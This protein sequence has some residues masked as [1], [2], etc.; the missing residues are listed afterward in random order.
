MKIVFH[1]RVYAWLKQLAARY[2]PQQEKII[3][4][5]KPY[6]EKIR[7]WWLPQQEKIAQWATPRLAQFKAHWHSL[8]AR[9]K[10]IVLGGAIVAAALLF[11]ALM[12]SPLNAHLDNLRTQIQAEK[13]TAAW[14]QAADKQIRSL[15]SKQGPVSVKK[16]ARRLN[17]IE[18][19]LR[20]APLSKNLT[21]LT[22][23]SNEEIH[24]V[25]DQVDFDTLLAWLMPFTQEHE[26]IVKQASIRRLNNI[27]LVQAEFTFSY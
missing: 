5:C 8:A 19:D 13:K 4:Q 23:N 10:S 7:L 6:L 3:T 9:E 18:E 15:E 27:G 20:Q 22:Q 21:Q 24:C 26:L 12:W 14:I 2:Q 16:Q 11:Y 25:Y 17:K 1:K